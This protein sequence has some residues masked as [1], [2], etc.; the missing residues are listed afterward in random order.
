MT[1][2]IR[3][4]EDRF[5]S[6]PDWPYEPKFVD[7]D[8]VRVHYVDEGPA[9]GAPILMLHGEPT[10]SYL[11][12]K[13]IAS[14]LLKGHRCVAIDLVGFGRSDKA[15][16]P[17]AYSYRSHLD[18][19]W[20]AVRTLNLQN[21]TLFCQDW[22][23]LLGLR[24][25]ADEPERFA[26]VCASNTFLPTGDRDPGDGFRKW[27]EY[28]QTVPDFHVGGIVKGGCVRPVDQATIDAYNAPFPDDTFKVAARRFPLLV[29]ITPDD[30]ASED[31][32]KAWESLKKYDR[33]FLTLFG[34]MDPVTKGGERVLQKLIPGSAGQPHEIIENAG[35]FI[36]EDA[37]EEL[38]EK[39]DAWIR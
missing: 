6:I 39:L 24:M 25:V 1:N 34:D 20:G 31:N 4:P 17:E 28:S 38:A 15:T 13:M 5:T 22:G 23:G 19:L 14:L 32:R 12:R 29:P 30:P 35:H 2:L 3:T 27:R 7:V 36:Q 37:G 16:D 11:Y 9:D 33:P 10:W 26:R 18:W 8:G 21:I